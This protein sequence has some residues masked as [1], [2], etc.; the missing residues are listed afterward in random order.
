MTSFDA[1]PVTDTLFFTDFSYLPTTNQEPEDELLTLPKIKKRPS[2]LALKL[3]IATG[4]A[5]IASIA[6]FKAY[7]DQSLSPS[8]GNHDVDRSIFKSFHNRFH[9][10]YEKGCDSAALK[11]ETLFFNL[12][13]TDKYLSDLVGKPSK[14]LNGALQGFLEGRNLNAFRCA[15]TSFEEPLSD[16]INDKLLELV[17]KRLS[18]PE[19]EEFIGFLLDEDANPNQH[20]RDIV[21]KDTTLAYSTPLLRALKKGNLRIVET[22]LEKGADVELPL[23]RKNAAQGALTQTTTFNYFVKFSKAHQVTGRKVQSICE[24]FKKVTT[25]MIPYTAH[26]KE[27]FDS[28]DCKSM[29]KKVFN[30]A[31]KGSCKIVFQNDPF[32]AIAKPDSTHNVPKDY[33]NPLVNNLDVL[34]LVSKLG[35]SISHAATEILAGTANIIWNQWGHFYK[36]WLDSNY[37]SSAPLT[38]NEARKTLGLGREIFGFGSSYTKKELKKANREALQKLHPD[39]TQQIVEKLPSNEQE[40]AKQKYARQFYRVTESYELLMKKNGWG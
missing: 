23:L 21:P 25:L 24:L 36:S 6:L 20:F 32:Y 28:D 7:Y 18:R 8:L 37:K 16:R 33:K 30:L 5:A 11:A 31:E 2:Y 14:E 29:R 13:E 3:A 40:A 35:Q 4:F 27:T 26:C 12:F 34:Y 15:Y 22:L 1:Q 17:F 19:S 39:K 38:V 9:G 10:E